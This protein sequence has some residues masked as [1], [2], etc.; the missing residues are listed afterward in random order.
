MRRLLLFLLVFG[1]GSAVLWHFESKRRTDEAARAVEKASR[2]P[3]L[4]REPAAANP[5]PPQGAAPGTVLASEPGTDPG[6]GDPAPGPGSGHTPDPDS[7]APSAGDLSGEDAEPQSSGHVLLRGEFHVD[8]PGSDAR[9]NLGL[10]I[11]D[12]QPQD[13]RGQRYLARDIKIKSREA[14]ASGALVLRETIDAESGAFRFQLDSGRPTGL[15]DSEPLAL[16]AVVVVRHLDAPVVPLEVRAP[17]LNAYPN[18]ARY[19]SVEDDVVEIEGPGLS[20]SGRAVVFDGEARRLRL[21]R[22]AH[23]KFALEDGRIVD[24]WTTGDGPL[25]LTRKADDTLEAVA[26]GGARLELLGD[27]PATVDAERIEVSLR[28]APNGGLWL[29]SARARGTVVVKQGDDRYTGDSARVLSPGGELSSVVL[30]DSPEAR[31]TL[32]DTDGRDMDVFVRGAG[33]LKVDIVRV[34][35]GQRRAS[36]VFQGPGL[37]QVPDR[38]LDINFEDRVEGKARE[39]EGRA[40]FIAAGGVVARRADVRIETASLTATVLGDSREE[41]LDELIVVTEGP[42]ILTGKSEAGDDVRVDAGLGLAARLIGEAERDGRWLLDRAEDVTVV[43]GGPD[44]YRVE[45]GVLRD[46]DLQ[47]RT[48]TAD[49]DVAYASLLGEASGTAGMVRGQELVVLSGDATRP[50]RIV[51]APDPK[52]LEGPDSAAKLAPLGEARAGEPQRMDARADADDARRARR[53]AR[54]PRDR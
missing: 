44:P 33:P 48:F 28:S 30:N 21:G 54:V 50:A 23:V 17:R 20:G 15:A 13:S 53:R 32:R 51:L 11:A 38:S 52:L 31:V 16:K 37:V 24:F 22:G 8:W 25:E 35:D 4:E 45:A 46:G 49:G 19:E 2:D 12:L 3:R 9:P 42:T 7:G 39:D 18:S 26:E 43:A 6:A 27:P 41:A 5:T 29:D 34:E 10:D 47:A 14:D 1:A 36:F 40:V